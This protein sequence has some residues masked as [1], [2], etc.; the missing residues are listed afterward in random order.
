MRLTHYPQLADHGR[1]REIARLGLDREEHRPYLTEVVEQVADRL[2]TPF[3]VVDVLLDD[4]Q[5]FLA[6]CGPIPGW[7]AEVGGTPIEW[8][9]CTPM[10]E[11]RVPHAVEDFTLDPVHRQNPLVAVEGLRSYIGA[12]LISSEGFVLGGLCALDLRRRQF[13]DRDLEYLTDMAARTV[14][15]IEDQAK[16]AS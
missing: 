7:L 13:D 10:L 5:V 16:A 14:R 15:R 9:F 1:L 2:G 6:G 4:A 11:H 8:A 3:A 12:P